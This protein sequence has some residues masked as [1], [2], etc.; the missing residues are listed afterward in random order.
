MFI[1]LCYVGRFYRRFFRALLLRIEWNNLRKC[2]VELNSWPSVYRVA[3]L[4][5]C[6]S[7]LNAYKLIK[8]KSK[9]IN[10][11]KREKIIKLTPKNASQ[12]LRNQIMNKLYAC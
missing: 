5:T 12:Y 8:R 2:V 10:T 11:N 4:S 7:H 3:S 1:S 9:L 6:L